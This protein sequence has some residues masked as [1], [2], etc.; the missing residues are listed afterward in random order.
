[1]KLYLYLRSRMP[2]W[3]AL[4]IAAIWLALLIVLAIFFA[5]EPQAEF[6]YGNI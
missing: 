4:A 2:S 6:R 5:A 3:L 1:M